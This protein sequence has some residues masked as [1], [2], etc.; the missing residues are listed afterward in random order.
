MDSPTLCIPRFL[1]VLQQTRTTNLLRARR[2][3]IPGTG[4]LGGYS[5]NTV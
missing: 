4:R 1:A 3:G 5:R 2:P